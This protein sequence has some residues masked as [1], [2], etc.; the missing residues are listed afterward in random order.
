MGEVTEDLSTLAYAA[1]EALD[2]LREIDEFEYSLPDE[3]TERIRNT[4][5]NLRVLSESLTHLEKK[6]KGGM[7]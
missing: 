6:A 1:Q 7:S 4:R 5:S 3:V 2:W